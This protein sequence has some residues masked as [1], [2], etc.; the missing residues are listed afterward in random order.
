MSGGNLQVG[1]PATSHADERAQVRLGSRVR[2]RDP[3]GEAEFRIV[4]AEEVD[5]LERRMSMESPLG[6][7]L[8][9]RGV[10]DRVEVLTPRGHCTVTIVGVDPGSA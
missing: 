10:G 3:D 4:S 1:Q 5:L 8:L 7:A 9:G 6:R 2:F